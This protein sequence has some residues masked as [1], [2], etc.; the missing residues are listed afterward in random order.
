[1]VG[2]RVFNERARNAIDTVYGA[3]TSGASWLFISLS[4]PTLSIDMN[5]YPIGEPARILGILASMIPARVN[6]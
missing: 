2:A 6:G 1:M 4:G 5:E 3:V